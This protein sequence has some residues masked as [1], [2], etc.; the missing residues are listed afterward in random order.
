MVE[1]DVKRT[2]HYVEETEVIL[3]VVVAPGKEACGGQNEDWKVTGLLS[4][5]LLLLLLLRRRTRLDGLCGGGD[6]GAADGG[7]NGCGR[8]LLE[9]IGGV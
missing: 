5:H 1:F 7:E 8:R 9:A 6:D 3:A 2:C 4:L